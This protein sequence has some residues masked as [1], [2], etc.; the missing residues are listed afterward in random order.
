MVR[1]PSPPRG[2]LRPY[3]IECMVADWW[4]SRRDPDVMRQPRG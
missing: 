2:G 3:V 4:G 1:A